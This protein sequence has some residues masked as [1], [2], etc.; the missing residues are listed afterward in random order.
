[1]TGQI[2]PGVEMPHL[3]GI[4][5]RWVDVRGERFHVAES[6]SADPGAPVV[7][8]LHGWPQHWWCWRKVIPGLVPDTRVV[9]L[10][11]RGHGWSS[12]PDHGYR[13]EEL[14]D[15][16]FAVLDELG[17][18]RV[19][20]VGH[21]WGG[22]VGFLAALREPERFDALVALGIL[23]P[24]QR[25]SPE[26]IA[27]AWRVGY[28]PVLAAPLLGSSLLRTQPW[29]VSEMIRLGTSER[30]AIDPATRRQYAEVLRSPARANASVQMYRTFLLHELPH[31][32][33]YQQSYLTVPTRL[34]VGRDD[35]VAN[36]AFL[37]GWQ[38]HAADMTIEYIDRVGHFVPEESPARVIHAIR[39]NGR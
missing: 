28:Q 4:A 6:A 2:D 22:W 12:A 10:D 25:L 14:V 29:V 17:H 27:N 8:L 37:D 20:L 34:L 13:K 32:G 9:A 11:L 3:D 35:P 39:A 38:E 31:L 16:V 21:D 26:T 33:R 19:T 1:V 24:F 30:D 7:V 15:D 36:G 5:H 23:H 18:D